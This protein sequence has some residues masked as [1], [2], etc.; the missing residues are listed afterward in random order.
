M[1]ILAALRTRLAADATVAALVAARIYRNLAPQGAAA[2]YLVGQMISAPR[3]ATLDGP[4]GLV[5]ARVQWGAWA[6]TPAAAEAAIDA[7]RASLDGFAG[8]I[9]GTVVQGCT[10][11]DQFDLY[12]PE[13][14]RH[15]V[16]FDITVS[17][18][19]A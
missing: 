16:L 4:T 9:A 13:T 12:D 7:V 1:S 15:G 18:V 11:A 5:T 14:D 2:P 8:T 17:F 19:E 3:V 10:A 6:T